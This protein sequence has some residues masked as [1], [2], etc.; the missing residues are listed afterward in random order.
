MMSLIKPEYEVAR[1]YIPL[2]LSEM[3]DVV[4]KG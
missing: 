1:L 3:K 2:C 4:F